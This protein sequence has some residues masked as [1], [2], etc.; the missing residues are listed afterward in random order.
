MSEM[1]ESDELLAEENDSKNKGL[2]PL[3]SKFHLLK[4]FREKAPGS[5]K[6]DQS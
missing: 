2:G 6:H 1:Q 3:D 5:H 4:E